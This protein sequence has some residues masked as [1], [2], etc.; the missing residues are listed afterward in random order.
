[1]GVSRLIAS[2][3]WNVRP[4]DPQTLISAAVLMIGVAALASAIPAHRAT[5][6]DPMQALRCE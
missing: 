3:L 1:M 5:R 2:L 4:F 6:I